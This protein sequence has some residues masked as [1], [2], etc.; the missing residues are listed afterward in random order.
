MGSV[1]DFLEKHYLHFNARETL[2]AAKAYE[3]HIQ[4]NG[5]ILLSLAGAMSTAEIGIILARMIRTGKVHA[6]SCTGANL[7]EDVYNLIAHNSYKVIQDWRVL[8]PA[9]ERE[10]FHSGYNRVTDTC[11]PEKAMLKVDSL[12]IERWRRACKEN[13][14]KTLAECFCE[15]L[16]S[17]ELEA[18]YEIDPK[19]SWVL[20]AA[21]ERIPIWSPGWEDSTTGNTLAAAVLRGDIPHHTCMKT[22]T[23]Q[24]ESLVQWYL[25]EVKE[26]G[27]SRAPG[28]FQVGGGIAGDFAICVL[29]TI[30]V[31]L[32][33]PHVPK[34]GYFCQIS[35][36]VTSY[37]SYSGAVPNEK[38]SWGKLHEVTPS[39]MIQSDAT[40]V[41]PL[42]FGY[43]LND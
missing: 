18:D 8:S 7:E 9:K 37:G 42:I 25:N 12:L 22:G 35:D 13:E 17:G 40:I 23:E 2:Q 5:K 20:A 32:K 33:M 30:A 14:R 3:A 27:D 16:L 28:F 26:L 38:I 19:H 39:F 36:S 10:L 34:W 31:D 15:I 4:G 29:P 6:I 24:F 1:R 21:E 11:I 41:V 43:L